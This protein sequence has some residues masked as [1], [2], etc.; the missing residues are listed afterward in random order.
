MADISARG[1]WQP[2]ATALFD[3]RV[4][5]SD[6]P[7]YLS[8]SPDAVLRTAEREKKSKYSLACE[9]S[10]ASFTPLCFTIDG[11]V[12]PEMSSFMKRLADRLAVKWDLSYSVTINWLRSRLSIALLRATNLCIRGSRTKWRGL[13]FED[14][15]GIITNIL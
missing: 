6:A 11:L 8:K 10:D 4:I 7:S 12:A 9:R 5:D 1:V 14:G 3:V 15:G 2:Q 13:A